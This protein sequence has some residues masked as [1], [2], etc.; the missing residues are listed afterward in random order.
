MSTDIHLIWGRLF[1]SQLVRG[2]RYRINYLFLTIVHSAAG[3]P[4]T[5]SQSISG[6]N[7]GADKYCL[8]IDIHL[9]HVVALWPLSM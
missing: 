9:S 2:Y 8:S 5:R 1:H 6:E 3:G 7:K 4:E